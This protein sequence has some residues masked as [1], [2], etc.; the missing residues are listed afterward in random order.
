MD[1]DL[2]LA[3][4]SLDIDYKMMMMKKMIYYFKKMY[5]YVGVSGSGK[6][7]RAYNFLKQDRSAV[8]ISQDKIRDQL[9]RRDHEDRDATHWRMHEV[10]NEEMRMYRYAV[11][12]LRT[13]IVANPNL[14]PYER[15]AWESRARSNGYSFDYVRFDVSYQVAFE[16]NCRKGVRALPEAEFNRQWC[17]WTSYRKTCGLLK[18]YVPDPSKPPAVV[19][20]FESLGYNPNVTEEDLN[21][22]RQSNNFTNERFYPRV[23]W[24]AV[25]QS[26]VASLGNCNVVVVARNTSEEYKHSILEW[27]RCNTNFGFNQTDLYVNDDSERWIQELIQHVQQVYHVKIVF[28]KSKY[29]AVDWYDA[30][31]EEVFVASSMFFLEK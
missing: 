20:E 10:R 13:V 4:H 22:S 28:A 19:V 18:Q 3:F 24:N 11:E 30:G 7:K 27:L 16:R 25:L 5:I 8:V 26:H 6:I 14:E 31:F 23:Q 12:E 2:E 17:K 9:A 29:S 21:A 1:L 15:E